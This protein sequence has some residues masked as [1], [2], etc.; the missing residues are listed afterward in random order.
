MNDYAVL[1][2]EDGYTVFKFN[3]TKVRFLTSKKLERYTK[4]LQWDNGYIVVMAKYQGL[5]EM[6]EYIDMVPILERLYYDVSA[7][8]SP[9][10]GVRIDNVA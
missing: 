1:G 5:K 6:E 3:G 2:N 4:V 9:I 7:F 8:L 10:K